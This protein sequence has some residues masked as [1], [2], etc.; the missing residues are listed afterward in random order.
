MKSLKYCENYQNVIRATKWANA[1]GKVSLIDLLDT[2]L[3]QTF[4]LG[5]KNQPVSVNY[6]KVMCNEMRYAYIKQK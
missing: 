5:E 4:N 2:G 3:L 6:N 1:V